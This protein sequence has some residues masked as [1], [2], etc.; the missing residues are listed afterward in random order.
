MKAMATHGGQKQW[1]L[2]VFTR[3]IG[4]NWFS[5]PVYV[6][7][8]LGVAYFDEAGVSSLSWPGILVQM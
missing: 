8:L 2:M 1:L 7:I 4:C 6:Q 3:I 5:Q